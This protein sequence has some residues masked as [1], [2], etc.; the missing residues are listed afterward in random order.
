MIR[1]GTAG[2]SYPDWEGIVYPRGSQGSG[3]ALEALVRMFD[4]LEIN[5]TFY[6]PPTA[7]MT[8]AWVKKVAE[9]P[10]FR[11]TAKLWQG[12]THHR[13]Q[14]HTREEREFREGIAPLQEAE[15]LGALLVQFPW[16]F[17]STPENRAYLE[18]LLDRFADFPLAVELRHASWMRDDVVE[19]LSRKGAG[20]CNIDQPEMRDTITAT[21]VLTPGPG[22]VRLHG[23]NRDAWV[24][25]DAGRDERYDYLYNR[26][27][28]GVWGEKIKSMQKTSRGKDIYVIA[29]NHYRGQAPANALEMIALL[30]GKKVPVPA[31][32]ERAYPQLTAI[33]DRSAP[34]EDQGDQ[35]VL[36]L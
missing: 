30:T 16:S 9:K 22:Y 7:R 33:A 19:M 20:F 4:V 23:R 15:R 31:S 3:R 14:A 28:I 10:L 17:R 1:V 13:G 27:E 26:D 8:A 24:R 12:F 18:A 34:P 5:V 11:F 32:L 2:W 25:A 29:N 6:R 36:P 21:T 35:G